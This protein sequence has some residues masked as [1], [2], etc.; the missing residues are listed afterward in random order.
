MDYN[1]FLEEYKKNEKDGVYWIMTTLKDMGNNKEYDDFQTILDNA[2][3][4]IFKDGSVTIALVAW[5]FGDH[6]DRSNYVKKAIQYYDELKGDGYGEKLFG[7]FGNGSW[8]PS[9]G[10]ERRMFDIKE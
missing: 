10:F 2:E 6:L 3:P 4:E 9:F 7:R 5:W 1:T 8:K